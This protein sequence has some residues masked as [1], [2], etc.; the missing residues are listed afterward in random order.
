[1]AKKIQHGERRRRQVNLRIDAPLYEAVEA[2]ARRERRS[3]AQ[4]ARWLLEEGLRVRTTGSTP[5]DDT[6]ADDIGTLAARGG[7]FDW[8][9]DE[10]DLYDDRSGEPL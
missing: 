5:V 9:A 8:L 4:M 3:V 10:P 6:R 7:G 2:V 1:V